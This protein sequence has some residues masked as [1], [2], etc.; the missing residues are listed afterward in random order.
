MSRDRYIKH[1]KEYVTP[2][3]NVYINYEAANISVRV[4]GGFDS[5]VMLYIVAKAVYE[6]SPTSIIRPVTI[7]KGNPTDMKQYDGFDCYEYADTIIN[8]VRS[9][10]PSLT[11]ED[12]V[13]DAANYWW[14][15]RDDN[16]RP[17]GS[18]VYTQN[19]ISDYMVWRYVDSDSQQNLDNLMYCEYVGT[20][21]NPPA[22]S[23]PSS[24]EKHRD[25]HADNSV[26]KDSP[27]VIEYHKKHVYV[28]PFR[29][30]DKRLTFWLADSQGILDTLLEITRSCEGNFEETDDFTKE[31]GTCWWCQERDW[32]NKNYKEMKK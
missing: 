23:I 13:K 7:I 22:G 26:S 29:N 9:R 6:N 20:T 18:Y 17:D 10:F 27:T 14:I 16:G 28:E 15:T 1:S 5:A 8:W 2:Y 31:C 30:F 32:A 24:F 3:G 19:L 11:I 25:N 21:K 4:S 12:T